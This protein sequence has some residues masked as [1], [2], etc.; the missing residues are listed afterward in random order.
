LA[1]RFILG[2]CLL[3]IVVKFSAMSARPH[4]ALQPVWQGALAGLD[5][6]DWIISSGLMD[7]PLW[8]T[9]HQNGFDPPILHPKLDHLK[10]YRLLLARQFGEP[11]WQSLAGVGVGALVA[12]RLR[13]PGVDHR[14]V[15]ALE[16]YQPLVVAGFQPIP[17]FARYEPFGIDAPPDFETLMAGQSNFWSACEKALGASFRQHDE[18][19]RTARQLRNYFSRL[20][21]DLGV[22]LEHHGHAE[23]A[24]RQYRQALRF[25]PDNLSARIN[26]VAHAIP[27]DMPSNLVQE[28]ERQCRPGL[29]AALA[30]NTGLIA[31]RPAIRLIEELC[32]WHSG[33]WET[34]GAL[35]AILSQH[36]AGRTNEAYRA[37]L[38]YAA[39]QPENRSVWILAAALAHER[40]DPSVIEQA[41]DRM[42]RRDEMWAPLLMILGEQSLRAGN[43]AEA[44]RH[45]EEAHRY[46]PL[47]VR[48]LESLIKLD[49]HG[50]GG[51]NQER[52]LRQLLS[53]D[54]WN[55]WGNFVLGL[56]LARS[57]DDAQAE[58]ALLTAVSRQPLA[59]ACNNLAWLLLNQKRYSEA[60]FYI[61]Q[62]IQIEPYGA[63]SWDTLAAIFISREEWNSAAVALQTALR[64]DPRNAEAVSHYLV[65]KEKTGKTFPEGEQG[66]RHE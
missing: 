12:E 61:R 52:H 27:P 57:R 51:E 25:V 43:F 26:L 5:K 4:Q 31:Q 28:V 32:Q 66:L 20:A 55:P 10:R 56:Q 23:D 35:T 60:L 6:N 63:A 22:A 34:T 39:K 47:N 41:K 53:I 59:V 58:I 37:L 49:I 54:P 50:Q 62:A 15:V 48:I 64:L 65:W 16:D 9:G 42:N 36:M 45:L 11:R 3:G 29:L 38:D 30:G 40:N 7:A 14:G 24:V 46:W 18:V 2:F 33:D 13:A 1:R 8:V 44:Y 21:N 19:E 17:R